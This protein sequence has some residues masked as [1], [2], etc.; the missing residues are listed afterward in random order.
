MRRRKRGDK[1]SRG[2]QRNALRKVSE[3]NSIS[4]NEHHSQGMRE[5]SGYI[6]LNNTF[7]KVLYHE[8]Y[9]QK[10]FIVSDVPFEVS[11]KTAVPNLCVTRGQFC[12]GN[13]L[14]TDLG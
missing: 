12:G 9:P 2:Q 1:Y 11:S 4:D 8:Y 7:L 3:A 13:N 5:M 6:S 14:S 10:F